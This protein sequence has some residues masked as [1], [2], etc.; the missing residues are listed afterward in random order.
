MEMGEGVRREEWKWH[1]TY[2]AR[3]RGR[4]AQ[5]CNCMWGSC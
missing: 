5:R 4:M 3:R 1:T 2:D